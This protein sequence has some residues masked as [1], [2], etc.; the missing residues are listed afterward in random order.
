M[1]GFFES[2]LQYGDYK[3]SKNVPIFIVDILEQTLPNFDLERDSQL[4]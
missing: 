3:E 4:H 2:C 1:H